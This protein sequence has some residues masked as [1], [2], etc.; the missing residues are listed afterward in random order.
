MGKGGLTR[1][2]TAIIILVAVISAAFSGLTMLYI[3]KKQ[4]SSYLDRS[5]QV[6]AQKYA[7][8][9]ENYYQEYGTLEGLQS[10]IMD[11]G[12]AGNNFRHGR[13]FQAVQMGRRIIIADKESIIV[14]DSADLLTGQ[15]MELLRKNLLA[16]PLFSGGNQIGT[17]YVSSPL[18]AGIV[19]LEN[20]FLT[21]INKNISISIII[22]AFLAFLLGLFLSRSITRPM[23]DLSSAIHEVARG[24]LGTRLEPRGER[25]FV[26][27]ATDFNTMARQ[28][29]EHEESRVRL[30]SNIAH[31]LRTPLSIIRGQLEAIQSGKLEINEEISSTLVDETIR[32]TRLV[33][34]LETIG[35]AESG[36]LKLNKTVIKINDLVERLLPLRLTMEEDNIKFQVQIEDGLQEVKADFNRLTQVLI[37][38]LT[39]A[40]HHTPSGG[41][42]ILTIKRQENRIAFSIADNGSGISDKDLPNIFERFYRIDES[43][44]RKS[45]GT[46]LGLAIARRY[47]EAHKGQIWVE[48]SV[49]QGTTFYFTLPCA[50]EVLC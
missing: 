19:S 28:L 38:L 4:F 22:V 10:F 9:I 41:E 14:A 36:V 23:A 44:N 12:V 11:T 18:Q 33:S 32:L 31:E 2:V 15:K 24:N 17:L 1:R 39:N 48:S 13:R 16:Y 29:M 45:G 26:S 40:M 35:L 7:P 30:I 49:G 27:L 47:V 25:E 42:V 43:R 8:N 34:D 50:A 20:D 46:G 3:S 5:S 6:L 21:N 37:N